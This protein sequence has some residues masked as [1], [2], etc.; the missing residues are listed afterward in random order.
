ML[1]QQVLHT[2]Y[3]TKLHTSY[4][5][6]SF[7]KDQTRVVF[8]FVF[9]M[10][11]LSQF[12]FSEG[13][14][15]GCDSFKHWIRWG[16]I[17]FC[18]YCPKQN[19]IKI[20]LVDVYKQDDCELYALAN[21]TTLCHGELPPSKQ[22]YIQ[23]EMRPHRLK[24]SNP[25]VFPSENRNWDHNYI[26]KTKL[27]SVHCSCRLPERRMIQCMKCEVWYHEECE[28]VVTRAWIDADYPWICRKCISQR[29]TT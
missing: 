9:L 2:P 20:D 4:T 21:A 28:V 12:Q 13:N 24:P 18:I 10:Q 5:E 25:S 7:S 19:R 6:S 1:L 11:L 8:C 3:D 27:V 26:T 22:Y 29:R 15:G 16:R 17:S 23:K 14:T